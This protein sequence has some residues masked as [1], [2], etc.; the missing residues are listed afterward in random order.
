MKYKYETHLHTSQASRCGASTGAEQAAFI[1]EQ[2]YAGMFVTDHFFN[3]NCAVPTDLS[4]EE[5]V[6]QYCAGYRDAKAMGDKIGLDVFFGIEWNF[7]NDE[8]LLYGVSEEWLLAHPDMLCWD[9]AELFRQI[10]A[11]GGLMVQ[12]HPFRDRPYVG[13][14]HLH[15]E[16]VHAIELVNSGNDVRNDAMA[17][18]YAKHFGLHTT[19]G[20]DLHKN[21]LPDRGLKGIEADE[22]ITCPEDFVKLI[23]SG[24]GYAPIVFPED[25]P[26]LTD[27]D[28]SPKP[29]EMIG[30]DGSDRSEEI[31]A[32]MGDRFVKE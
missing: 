13:K 30:F 7:N 8:Y 26:E 29:M 24:T 23:K 3:G 6:H 27:E 28:L 2:G 14:I 31:I 16:H 21:K 12:A 17:A 22:P 20:S 18:V 5:R 32:L 9:H 11:I 1:K 19:A 4:W 10:N 25:I 15:P